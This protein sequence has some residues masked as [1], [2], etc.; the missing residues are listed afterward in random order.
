MNAMLPQ[1][2]VMN[3]HPELP[4]IREERTLRRSHS[5]RVFWSDLSAGAADQPATGTA[6]LQWLRASRVR[7]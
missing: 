1:T 4:Q 2:Q 3:I 5:P 6:G 7:V